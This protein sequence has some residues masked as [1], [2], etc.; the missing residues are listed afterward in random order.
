MKVIILKPPVFI[1]SIPVGAVHVLNVPID[2]WRRIIRSAD[3]IATCSSISSA[4]L[5]VLIV[6]SIM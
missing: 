3:R 1:S 6:L 5:T 4:P 2:K